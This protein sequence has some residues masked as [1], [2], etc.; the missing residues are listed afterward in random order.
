MSVYVVWHLCVV[1]AAYVVLLV[2]F[3]GGAFVA[4]REG[5]K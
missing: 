5:G 4:V 1:V 2:G 3:G